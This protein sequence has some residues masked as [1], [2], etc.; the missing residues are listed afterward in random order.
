MRTGLKLDGDREGCRYRRTLGFSVF[1]PT[2]TGSGKSER[3]VRC[4]DKLSS[5]RCWIDWYETFP[6]R[7]EPL[8]LN[9]Q[10]PITNIKKV[11]KFLRDS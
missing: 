9:T 5:C 10:H 8:Q 2:D 7:I 11:S 6:T 3:M 1:D 4:P